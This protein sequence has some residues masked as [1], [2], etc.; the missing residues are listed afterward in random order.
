MLNFL[1]KPTAEAPK[2]HWAPFMPPQN[3]VFR[4][5]DLQHNQITIGEFLHNFDI[6]I[7]LSISVTLAPEGHGA[8]VLPDQD[9]GSKK[10]TNLTKLEVPCNFCSIKFS[11][12]CTPEA[13]EAP[14]TCRVGGTN[15]KPSHKPSCPQGPSLLK[16]HP[17]LS[18][19]LDFYREWTD[20]HTQF[21]FSIID[22]TTF[23]V[24]RKSWFCF[25]LAKK[26]IFANIYFMN[27]RFCGNFEAIYERGCCSK[28]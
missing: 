24:C 10:M 3:P 13:P 22:G 11:P 7:T 9:L 12:K 28:P 27:L 2:P 25:F 4:V 17:D 20:K 26:A 14:C 6:K 23:E 15:L 21:I 5:Q 1:P 18:C 8:K 16:F 19:H